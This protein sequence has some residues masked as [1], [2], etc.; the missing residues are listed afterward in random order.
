MGPYPPAPKNGTLYLKT[1][2]STY[3][4]YLLRMFNDMKQIRVT[5]MQKTKTIRN[6]ENTFSQHCNKVMWPHIY[7]MLLLA[8]NC[9]IH[10]DKTTAESFVRD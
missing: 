3:S 5:N 6:G 2:F 4:G 7:R 8:F 1:E 9:C 10:A